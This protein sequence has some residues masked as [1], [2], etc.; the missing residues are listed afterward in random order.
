MGK[1]WEGGDIA[2]VAGGGQKVN[3]LKESMEALKDKKEL[4]VMFVDR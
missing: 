1:K 2:K 4:L 3:L